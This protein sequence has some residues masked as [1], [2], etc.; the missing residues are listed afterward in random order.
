VS[1]AKGKHA[2]PCTVTPAYLSNE[3]EITSRWRECHNQ[4]MISIFCATYN[5]ETFIE[6]A[7]IGFLSQKTQFSF[8]VVIRDDASTDATKS[9]IE[10]YASRYPNIIRPFYNITNEFSEGKRPLPTMYPYLRGKYVALCEGDD[11]WV[12]PQ[13]LEKQVLFLEKNPEFVLSGH[14]AIVVDH[15]GSYIHRSKLPFFHKRN[16]SSKQL[17]EGR[18]FVLTLTMVF[19][20]V[21]EDQEA[22]IERSRVTNGDTFLLS[23]LG[24]HGGAYYHNDLKPAAYRVHAGGIWSPLH[25]DLKMANEAITFNTIGTYYQKIG[26]TELAKIWFKKARRAY[27][28][29]AGIHDHLTHVLSKL[30]FLGKFRAVY[31]WLRFYVTHKSEHSNSKL[32]KS[33]WVD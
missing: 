2:I 11:Y 30:L 6:Q 13:K 10:Y 32:F 16:Y 24:R 4:P 12:D 19:R 23:L 9:V 15:E 3:A 1:F 27:L 5:H 18:A 8:E 22:L 33:K 26:D 14:D 20:R 29:S 31:K 21:L 28:Q 7:I 17:R 25:D